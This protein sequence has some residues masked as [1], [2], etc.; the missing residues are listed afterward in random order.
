MNS[1][2]M[3]GTTVLARL[4]RTVEEI[5]GTSIVELRRRTPEEQRQA[6]EKRHGQKMRFV[7]RSPSVGRGNVMSD[8]IKTHEEIEAMLDEALR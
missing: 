8:R 3:V 5:T 4:E 7:S 1:S 6:V 2:A